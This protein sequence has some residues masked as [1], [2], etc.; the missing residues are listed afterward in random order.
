M[1]RDIAV[2]GDISRPRQ[3]VWF[4]EAIEAGLLG[5]EPGAGVDAL[6][7]GGMH[8][9]VVDEVGKVS[10]RTSFESSDWTNRLHI[11]LVVGA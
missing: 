7:A 10:W 2:L 3:H 5:T 9:L 6:C 8:T 4:K 1:I 11:G